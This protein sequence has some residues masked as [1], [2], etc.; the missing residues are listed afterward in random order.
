MRTTIIVFTVAWLLLG[1]NASPAAQSTST[2]LKR[3]GNLNVDCRGGARARDG[4]DITDFACGQRLEIERQ[5]KERGCTHSMPVDNWT[6][7]ARRPRT[8]SAVSG[9]AG[10]R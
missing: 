1:P 4:T 2:L 5:L 7:K 3:W 8:R 10:R 6:C 9:R